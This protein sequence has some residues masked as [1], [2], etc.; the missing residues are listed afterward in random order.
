MGL[1]LA[2]VIIGGVA[3]HL[4]PGTQSRSSVLGATAPTSV[5][6]VA[7]LLNGTLPEA[8]SVW[9]QSFAHVGAILLVTLGLTMGWLLA[10][11]RADVNPR[12]GAALAAVLLGFGLVSSLA[13]RF[14]Q[15][16]AYDGYWH[17]MPAWLFSFL[18]LLV[19]SLSVGIYLARSSWAWE[20]PVVL[21]IGAAA[22][23]VVAGAMLELTTS[24]AT[25]AL[26][27]E[28]GPAPLPGMVSDLENPQGMEIACWRDLGQMRT[29]PA[30]GGQ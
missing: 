15:Q 16:F 20:T 2:G 5:R 22:L 6:D 7:E 11:T 25:R 12:R 3:S 21:S 24:M 4:A 27:W 17:F 13:S 18:A 10:R 19:G 23:L 29:L 9:V 1:M 30:R 28:N 8:I 14:S 26:V